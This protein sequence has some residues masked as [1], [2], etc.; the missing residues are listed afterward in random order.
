MRPWF[1]AFDVLSNLI[2]A[3]T[4]E[5]CTRAEGGEG[6]RI[7]AHVMLCLAAAVVVV[8]IGTAST[9]SSQAGAVVLFAESGQRAEHVMSRPDQPASPGRGEEGGRQQ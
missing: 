2:P 6:S 4:S 3:P 9:A 7:P 1:V 5:P 8:A